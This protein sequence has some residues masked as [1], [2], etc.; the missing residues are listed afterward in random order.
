[1]GFLSRRR[2]FLIKLIVVVT[3][4]WFTVAFLLYTENR[5]LPNTLGAVANV[6]LPPAP[7]IQEALKRE[8]EEPAPPVRPKSD[9]EN[10]VLVPPQPN[11][12]EMGK[13]VV[14]PAN[15]SADMK[16]AVDEG[17]VKN[18]FNQYASDLISVR[19][20]LPDPRDAWLVVVQFF[21]INIIK[22]ITG[23]STFHLKIF[24]ICPIY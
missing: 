21:F 24:K 13:P 14:L 12:G 2:S 8:T 9:N 3:T 19:R 10:G 17:W 7:P 23:G 16:K 5:Q 22:F 15:M 4:A 18:A 6:E 20:S 1:M 11:F